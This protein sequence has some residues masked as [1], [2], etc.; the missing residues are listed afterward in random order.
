M[1][2]R[3]SLWKGLDSDSFMQYAAI[4]NAKGFVAESMS[5]AD[6]RIGSQEREQCL[7]AILRRGRADPDIVSILVEQDPHISID[8]SAMFKPSTAKPDA[9]A[10]YTILK[11]LC[12]NGAIGRKAFQTQKYMVA[13]VV[14]QEDTEELSNLISGTVHVKKGKTNLFARWSGRKQNK[15]GPRLSLWGKEIR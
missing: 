6:T 3:D 4:Q 2:L 12:Q 7:L 13:S 9:E 10:T 14:D 11:C 8:I 15:S 1:H 5:S